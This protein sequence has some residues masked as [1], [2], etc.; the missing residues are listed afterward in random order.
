MSDND[1]YQVKRQRP[2]ISVYMLH[3]VQLLIK[4]ATLNL[5][6]VFTCKY[7]LNRAYLLLESQGDTFYAEVKG[8]VSKAF[9]E[10]Q[11][12]NSSFSL[13][14]SG[15]ASIG[16]GGALSHQGFSGN[17]S[18]FHEQILSFKTTTKKV[19]FALLS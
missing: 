14:G 19:E 2:I 18:S 9:L 3:F 7:F 11:K 12:R 4:V 15:G 17:S 13:H 6:K 10:T 16:A 1:A 8:L 5:V